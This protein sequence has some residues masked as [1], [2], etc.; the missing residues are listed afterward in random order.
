MAVA[1]VLTLMDVRPRRVNRRILNLE[2]FYDFAA[3]LPQPAMAFAK[4]M[5]WINKDGNLQYGLS[6]KER[7]KYCITKN[8]FLLF[9]PFPIHNKCCDLFKKNQGHDYSRKTGRLPITGQMA[10]ESNLRTQHWLE[11]GCNGFQ[12]TSPVSN[13]MA[14]WFK[15][16][17]LAYLLNREIKIASVYGDIVA[18][19]GE[20][21]NHVDES[22]SI[23]D[24]GR[25]SLKTTGAERTGCMFCLFGAQNE[26]EDAQRLRVAEEFSNPK[27]L[28]HVLRGGAFDPQDRLW[29]PDNR[30]LGFWF[31][32]EWLNTFG[33]MNIWYPN[34]E[35]YLE[36]YHTKMTRDIINDF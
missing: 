2:G 4:V 22:L 11:N 27:I 20:R 26:T 18:E 35:K 9:A 19:T 10:S 14:F 3:D 32:I 25:T 1:E 29:K 16:D 13:P 24:E 31:V 30:G 21:V 6:A 12:M 7:S 33:R 8:Q 34:R 36:E 23:F 17:V 5:G 28:D 15:E